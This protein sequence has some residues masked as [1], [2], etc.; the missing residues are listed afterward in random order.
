[1]KNSGMRLAALIALAGGL[2]PAGSLAQDKT[3]GLWRG[4][5][6][7]ALSATSGNSSTQ[8]LSVN[9]D[10]ARL[11]AADKTA[12]GAFVNYGKSKSGGVSTTT[13]NRWAGFGQYDWNLGPRTVA[14]G[15]LGLEGDGLADLNLRATLAGGLGYKLIDEKDTKFTLYGGLGYSSDKYDVAKTIAGKTGTSFSRSSIYLAEES[16]HQLSASTAFK[17]RLDLFPG[18]SGDKALIAKFTAG[19]SV[20]MSSTMNLTVGLQDS[21]NSKPAAGQKK[22][23]LTLLTGVNVKFGAL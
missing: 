10:M 16:S 23:D 6:G 15:R 12:L 18:L 14:F 17:Q 13:A 21:Y 19:L 2:A 3:D 9:M 8:A 1:M 11:T 4:I 20:A 5:A 22:N 7:A